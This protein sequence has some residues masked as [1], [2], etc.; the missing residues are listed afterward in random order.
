MKPYSSCR[1]IYYNIRKEKACN[2]SNDDEDV[3]YEKVMKEQRT[4]PKSPDHVLVAIKNLLPHSMGE[5][6]KWYPCPQ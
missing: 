2:I 4:F 6:K 5:C 3:F 1:G